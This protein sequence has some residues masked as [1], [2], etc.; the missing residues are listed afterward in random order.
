MT[1]LDMTASQPNTGLFV[2]LNRGHIVTKKELA[3]RPSDRKGVCGFWPV[4]HSSQVFILGMN[5]CDLLIL[6]QSRKNL[7]QQ[8]SIIIHSSCNVA[9][10]QSFVNGML[11]FA[12]LIT[13]LYLG[14]L[15][16]L[17]FL[18]LICSFHPCACSQAHF[19]V[20]TCT[21]WTSDSFL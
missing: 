14:Q 20:C 6:N 9:I 10:M 5:I 4:E 21:W 1:E 15:V 12:V 3:P 8:A 2:G 13:S 19:C 7:G 17:S 11:C 16:D 18:A